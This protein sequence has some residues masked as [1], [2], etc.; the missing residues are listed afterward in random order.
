MAVLG[1]AGAVGL[2]VW[3][4]NTTYVAGN[5]VQGTNFGQNY[6]CL[7]GG[8]STNSAAA[9]PTGLGRITDG[10]VTWVSMLA[11]E[12]KFLLVQ[13]TSTDTAAKVYVGE[14]IGSSTNLSKTMVLY[15]GGHVLLTAPNDPVP[16]DKIFVWADRNASIAT[17]ER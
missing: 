15:S 3:N 13:N 5:L 16:Q 4:T 17:L 14:Y 9:A 7:V 10:T 12:R 8:K 11:K 2:P 6:M 1:P